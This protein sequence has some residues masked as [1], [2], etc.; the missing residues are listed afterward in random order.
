M[1]LRE[2]RILQKRSGGGQ[3]HKGRITSRGRDGPRG[4]FLIRSVMI[5]IS[6]D[7]L[8]SS[9]GGQERDM[10]VIGGQM[11]SKTVNEKYLTCEAR[12]LHGRREK[13][14]LPRVRGTS[15]HSRGL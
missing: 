13:L 10:D 1:L 3:L 4:H 7:H 12:K 15:F 11:Q 2:S 5:M 14:D 9:E 8:V 6:S